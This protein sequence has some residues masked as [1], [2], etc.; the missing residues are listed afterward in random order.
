MAERQSIEE[1]FWAKVDRDGPVPQ[2]APE[3]GQCWIWMAGRFKAGYGQFRFGGKP[4]TSHRVSWMITRNRSAVPIGYFI[5]HACDRRECVR[6]DHLWIGT[7]AANNRDMD[8]KGRRRAAS[9]LSS[10]RYTHPEKTPRGEGHHRAK[11][12]E[13]QV[14]EIRRRAGLGETKTPLAREFGVDQRS[15]RKI[16]TRETWK[17]VTS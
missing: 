14:R 7:A 9:G 3:I 15:V 1:L 6:P 5:L 11:L 4:T 8:E 2:H 12:T 10:G 17:H 13:T 16:I